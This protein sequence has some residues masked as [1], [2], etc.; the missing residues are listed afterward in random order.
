VGGREGGGS[1]APHPRG[2]LLANNLQAEVKTV[3]GNEETKGT[4]TAQEPIGGTEVNVNSTVII[5]L[6]EGPKTGTIP[7]DLVGE[8]VKDVENTLDD[9]KF[10]NVNTVAAKSEDPD[11]QPGAVISIS[12]KEGSTVPL[13]SKITVRYATGK[14]EVPNFEGLTRAAATRAA[15]DAGFGEPQ[16]VRRESSQPAGTVIDQ[17][18]RAG[19]TVDRDTR[20]EL[21][22]ATARPPAPPPTT[23]RPTE[24]PTKEPTEEPT[25]P[26]TRPPTTTPTSTASEGPAGNKGE[27]SSPR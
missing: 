6:N 11:T 25:E 13:D 26:T 24:E 21:T 5:T 10:S 8:D 17:S 20:I 4:I 27:S 2:Q 1:T 16:F 19:A 22:L 7:D 15:R 18:P 9:L 23:E 14:S 3:N 12:P